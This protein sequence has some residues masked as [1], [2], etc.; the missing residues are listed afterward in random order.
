MAYFTIK[1]KGYVKNS[2]RR[3]TTIA[4]QCIGLFTLFAILWHLPLLFAPASRQ[5][6]QPSWKSL[7]NEYYLVF[8]SPLLSSTNHDVL[9]MDPTIYLLPTDMG[10]SG[11]LRQYPPTSQLI[12]ESPTPSILIQPFQSRQSDKEFSG[13]TVLTMIQASFNTWNTQE[14]KLQPP[15]NISLEGESVWRVLGSIADWNPVATSVLPVLSSSEPLGAS[16][17][18]V[19][20]SSKGDPQFVTLERSAGLDK[21]DEVAVHFIKS[22]HFTPPDSIENS[23]APVW[24]F[25]KILWK[26][27]QVFAKP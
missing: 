24:G 9:W 20:V 8:K 3:K 13:Q 15:S 14:A 11:S 10:F 2:F 6:R 18:R 23:N 12:P 4:W 27:E 21:A 7:N 16:I 5:M 19:G 17:L 26:T 22:I 1:E 25:V